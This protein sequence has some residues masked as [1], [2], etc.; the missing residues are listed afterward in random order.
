MYNSSAVAVF[1]AVARES[2]MRSNCLFFVL[3]FCVI[4]GIGLSCSSGE[5]THSHVGIYAE[6]EEEIP[7]PLLCPHAEC[8]PPDC[9]G[10]A[11]DEANPCCALTYCLDGHCAPDA[12][13]GCGERE[14]RVD[15]ASCQAQCIA[16]S[17]C[18]K[19]CA[20][21]GECC[22][23][24]VCMTYAE[25]IRMC[26]PAVCAQCADMTPR[27]VLDDEACGAHCAAPQNC[28]TLCENDTECGSLGSC[29]EFIGGTKRCVPKAFK[30]LCH[31]CKE[32]CLFYP[33]TCE[34]ECKSAD[35]DLD[36]SDG[37]LDLDQGS[38]FTS[39]EETNVPT[40]CLDCCQT[41]VSDAECCVGH[42][43]AQEGSLSRCLPESCRDCLY[44]C[45]VTCP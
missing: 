5:K 44:G 1:S 4:L 30:E 7:I 3:L 25:D 38:E 8:K 35:G 9:C 18:M 40:A 27:C 28:G 22:S 39:D 42:Y 10:R 17:C 33:E 13:K 2:T 12:C 45:A 20:T 32:G 41:C 31:G 34:M 24:T 23:G 19:N 26:V 29:N 14:C 16:P 15:A 11:C 36:V 37:E 21:S 43:C 6:R